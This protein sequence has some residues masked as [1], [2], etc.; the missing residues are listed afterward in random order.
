[1]RTT[2]YD[3]IYYAALNIVEENII[4][5]RIIELFIVRDN[6]GAGVLI[7]I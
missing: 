6:I 2:V 4:R 7:H 3:G 5:I 1:M